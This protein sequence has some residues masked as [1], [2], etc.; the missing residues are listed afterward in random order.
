MK[1]FFWPRKKRWRKRVAALTGVGVSLAMIIALQLT[2]ATLAEEMPWDDVEDDEVDFELFEPEVEEVEEI[3]FDFDTLPEEPE[4]ALIPEPEAPE[5]E[6]VE[7][8]EIEAEEPEAGAAEAREPEGEPPEEKPPAILPEV[9]E[10]ETEDGEPPEEKPPA[11]LLE[12]P[13][14]ETEETDEPDAEA[15]P[16][17]DDGF[18][19]GWI[20]KTAKVRGESFIVTVRYNRD[21]GIPAD[22]VLTV[23]GTEDDSQYGNCFANAA[24][25]DGDYGFYLLDVSLISDGVDYASTYRYEVEVILDETLQAEAE[26]VQAMQIQGDKAKMLDATA[27]RGANN[28]VERITFQAESG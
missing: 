8:G 12:V 27:K 9:P 10:D 23:S 19:N 24:S 7:A 28:N 2:A 15:E 6:E 3:E 11:I 4:Q 26:D 25:G 13:E 16:A 1:G 21:S 5:A 14:D 20:T 18:E 17:E 22:A